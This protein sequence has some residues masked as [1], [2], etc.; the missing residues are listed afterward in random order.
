M[1]WRLIDAGDIA[2][3]SW[4]GEV[5]LYSASRAS[6]HH[7]GAAAGSVLAALLEHDGALSVD[8]IFALAFA[9]ISP[10]PAALTASERESIVRILDEFERTRLI[11]R[12]PA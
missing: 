11:E 5:V 6:T 10:A 2:W 3:R 12:V 7:V 9:E 4:Q 8:E 1:N